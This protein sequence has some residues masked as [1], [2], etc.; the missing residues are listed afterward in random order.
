MG[1]SK[2]AQ[3]NTVD[4][5]KSKSVAEMYSEA[6]TNADFDEK[7]GL[8]VF[9]RYCHVYKKGEMEEIV[10]QVGGAKLVESGYESGNHFI[11]LE[12]TE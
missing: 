10:H 4:A 9:Q 8:V 12:V 1:G 6:Y 11:I 5:A 2:G 7:K 3:N